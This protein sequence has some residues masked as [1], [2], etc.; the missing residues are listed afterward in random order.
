MCV[1][2]LPGALY[3]VEQIMTPVT[4][5]VFIVTVQIAQLTFLN[6]YNLS[7]GI[8]PCCKIQYRLLSG[9][10]QPPLTCPTLQVNKVTDLISFVP[11][12]P[13]RSKFLELLDLV[14]L[15]GLKDHLSPRTYVTHG[16]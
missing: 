1:C 14:C 9:F 4:L 12:H 13:E 10:V 2:L 15:W 7:Y 8:P 6:D 3:L 16:L 5:W 11:R